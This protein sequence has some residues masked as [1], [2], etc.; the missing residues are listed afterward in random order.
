MKKYKLSTLNKLC[1]I[2]ISC[3]TLITACEK[4]NAVD[5][6]QLAS[7]EITLKVF[8][9]CPIPRGAELRIVGTNLDKV[10][11]VILKG[12]GAITNI[13]RI[14]N[15]DIR[16]IVP[17]NAEPGIII[18]KAGSKEISSITELTFSEPISITS[19][20]PLSI[21]AGGVIKIQGDYLNLIKEVIFL[22]NVHVLQA[23]FKSQSRQ[24][25]E[26]TVPIKAQTGKVVVSNGA[27]LL[28][29]EEIAAGLE[30]KIPIWVYSD[31]ELVVTLPTFTS[32]SPG[33]IRAES[34]L[35]ITGKDFDLVESVSFGGDKKAESFTV[36]DAKT[37]ITVKVPKDAQDG[38]VVLTAFSGVK[39]LSATKLIMQVP[40]IAAISPNPVRNGAVLKITGTDLDLVN[41]VIFGGNTKGTIET[42]RTAT[43]INVKVPDNAKDGKITLV[44]LAKKEVQSAELALVKPVVSS[45]SPSPVPAGADVKMTGTNLDLVTSVTFAKDLVVSVKPTA[46]NEL[47]VTVPITAVSGV[48]VLTMVN[49]DKINCPELKV[50]E[51]TF[52]FL[53]KLPEP[54]AEIH[55]GEVLLL[56]IGN[57]DKLTDVQINGVST[58]FIIDKAKLYVLI[59]SRAGGK[60]ELK[61]ISSN[62]SASYTIPV[63]AMGFT[64][65]VIWE[66]MK[67]IGW[68]TGGAVALKAD[69]FKNV[70]VGA[71]MVFY[72][73]QK[74]NTWSQAQ[75]CQGGSGWPQFSFAELGGGGTWIPTDI[76]GWNNLD[77]NRQ[78]FVLT[79]DVL[80]KIIGNQDS[81]GIGMYIQGSDIIFS[82]V[83]IITQGGPAITV[84]W[85]GSIGPIGWSGSDLI[86]LDVNLLAPGKTL[87]F[88]F[89][90]GA[91]AQI[92]IMGGS[93]WEALPAWLAL[94]DGNRY[95]K[96]CAIDETNI[97]FKISQADIDCIKK[98]G[99]AL[100]VC[101]GNVTMKRLY[102]Y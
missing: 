77:Y 60:C 61:L 93:W 19:I 22:D 18:L 94:N 29:D 84:L 79:K 50:I 63:I 67:D 49:G 44:T 30:P 39:V 55:A 41:E 68:G 31:N 65:R 74:P 15:T 47:T 102:I 40:T 24:E 27:D 21:K 32:F 36:N 85:Q 83:T 52:A 75:L 51:P 8:G 33:T 17:Q 14:S 87:G 95:I 3:F 100:L 98:Q 69:D 72:F 38:S 99:T 43:E 5:T 35:T 96:N 92:E 88:D 71:I 70:P 6:N 73:Q 86:P 76:G 66:G 12:C 89:V 80:D 46:A 1:L 7:K 2:I 23:N 91:N 57:G 10:E 58:Q 4:E 54:D 56:E 48:V 90:C 53:L 26:V 101:G 42:G 64:E 78:E 97:E 25:I 62:G 28:T 11:S 82:K 45:Y 59:P 34:E 13:N 9:P 20:T 16:V 81:N 37:S